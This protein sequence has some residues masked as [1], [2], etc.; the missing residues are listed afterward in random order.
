MTRDELLG[1]WL[2]AERAATEAEVA[3]ANAGQGGSDPAFAELCKKAA[4]LR[5]EADR[6][7][8]LLP[9]NSAAE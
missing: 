5:A 4:E 6:L 3:V 8:R 1:A 9:P 7:F 2:A